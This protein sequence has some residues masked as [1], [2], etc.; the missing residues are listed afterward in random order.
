[1][2]LRYLRSSEGRR[3]GQRSGE[4]AGGVGNGG[5]VKREGKEGGEGGLFEIII[6]F[7]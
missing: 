5:M 6:D 7:A 1:M 2:V 3:D 4:K